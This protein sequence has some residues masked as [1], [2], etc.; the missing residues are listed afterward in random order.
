[1]VFG[2]APLH[3]LTSSN[4]SSFLGNLTDRPPNQVV[5]N[6]HWVKFVSANSHPAISSER[7]S[8]EN[9][10]IAVWVITYLVKGV[11]SSVVESIIQNLKLQMGPEFD[12]RPT[13]LL[14][15]FLFSSPSLFIFFSKCRRG[16]VYIVLLNS[17]DM[18]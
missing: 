8:K 14:F 7:Q 9:Q 16:R 6:T 11:G 4:P 18:L 1:M 15:F 13:R 10:I 5:T 3:H 17:F 12:S 2:S